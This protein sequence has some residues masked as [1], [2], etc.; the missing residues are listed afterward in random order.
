VRAP[1]PHPRMPHA[2][3]RTI[4]TTTTDHQ[5]LWFDSQGPERGTNAC[6]IA[7]VVWCRAAR[8]VVCCVA[9]VLTTG[10][11]RAGSTEPGGRDRG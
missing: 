3:I 9:V 5:A 2:G 6:F 1:G 4:T 7:C 11:V 10:I 8:V